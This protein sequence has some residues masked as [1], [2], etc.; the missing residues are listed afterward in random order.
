MIRT[1]I[2]LTEIEKQALHMIAVESGKKQS[3]LIRQAIDDLIESSSRDH[4]KLVMNRTAGIWKD[5]TDLA[6]PEEL[7][8]SWDRNPA[9]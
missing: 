8:R 9:L 7:R 4:R 6:L 5:R 1:Q 2:Y 3:E